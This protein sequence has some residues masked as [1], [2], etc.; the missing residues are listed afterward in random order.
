MSTPIPPVLGF[1]VLDPRRAWPLVLTRGILGVLFGVLALVWP[2]IT[3]LALA[4]LFGIYVLID[5]AGAI[6][7]A[8]RPGDGTHRIA[9]ALLGVLGLVA[10]IMTLVWPGVTVLVLATLV[11]AWAVVTG[12]MEIVAAIRLRK[13]IT[14][15]AFLIV[16]GA[17]SVIAGVLVLFHPIA[18]AFGVALLIGIYAV[19]YGVTLVVLSFRLR[20][21]AKSAD[22]ANQPN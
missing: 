1:A 22:P 12:I 15:E 13:Q 4:F 11:G 2:G 10:G 17:L 6:M 8:F 20:S 3:V 18:G 9:Y 14:G 7:Q 19:I 5:A 21:L 16:A